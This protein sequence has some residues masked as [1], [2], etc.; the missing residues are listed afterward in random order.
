[1]LKSKKEIHAHSIVLVGD[2]NPKIFQPA[3]FALHELIGENEAEN[4]DIQIVHPDVVIFKLDGITIQVTREKFHINTTNEALQ[5]SV[6]DLVIGT[7]KIL[8]HTPIKMIGIN[9]EIHYGIHSN[10]Q[11]NSFSNTLTPNKFWLSVFENVDMETIAVREIRKKGPVGFLRVLVQKSLKLQNGVF[12]NINDHFEVSDKDKSIGTVEI[13]GILES[14]WDISMSK[15]TN[16]IETI[17]K[18]KDEYDKK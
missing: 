8:M 6:R 11:W 18:N 1:M 17:W 14:Y 7:F 5:K 15:A 4:A 16:I 2:F 12:F 3:W 9:N 13:I 10:E